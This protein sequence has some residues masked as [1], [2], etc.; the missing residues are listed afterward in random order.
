MTKLKLLTPL[1]F[2]IASLGCVKEEPITPQPAPSTSTSTSTSGTTS[3]TT[4]GTSTSKS[5]G[6]STVSSSGSSGGSS[7]QPTATPDG[8]YM[9][10]NNVQINNVTNAGNA[11][12]TCN[13][14]VE[15]SIYDVR[16]AG[17]I[18]SYQ[19]G[20]IVRTQTFSSVAAD[21]AQLSVNCSE[22]VVTGTYTNQGTTSNSGMNAG[23]MVNSDAG[24]ESGGLELVYPQF[25][26]SFTFSAQYIPSSV[27][28]SNIETLN[29]DCVANTATLTSSSGFIWPNLLNP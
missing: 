19:N 3:G 25:I 4:T 6:G 7:P 14:G 21:H 23:S 29:Y 18:N 28:A 10:M 13:L 22:V 9:V 24:C 5:S 20:V 8:D 15:N 27:L 11:Q 26:G 12:P 17:K 16:L 2:T 1:L